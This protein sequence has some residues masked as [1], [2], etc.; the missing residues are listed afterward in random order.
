MPDLHKA[1]QHH[2]HA[3]HALAKGDVK[4]AA[5]HFGHALNALRSN[6]PSTPPTEPDADDGMTGD[7]EQEP[8]TKTFSRSRTV[9]MHLNQKKP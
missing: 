1:K 8:P 7:T 9:L 5:H 6:G 4:K 3:G 2:Q